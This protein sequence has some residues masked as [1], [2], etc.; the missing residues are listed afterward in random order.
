MITGSVETLMR[1]AP[2]TIAE[3]LSHAVKHI[4]EQFGDGYAK[5]NPELVG[6]FI[7]ASALDFHT[8]I[9]VKAAEERDVT[10]IEK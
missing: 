8:A 7:Q 2:I 1:Q 9:T 3:Y 4:D 6:A 10:V 5:K